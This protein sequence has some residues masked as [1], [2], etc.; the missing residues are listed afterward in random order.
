MI[1]FIIGLIGLPQLPGNSQPTVAQT[2]IG[3]TVRG[4]LGPNAL[5]VGVGPDGLLERVASPL[6]HDPPKLVVTG[7]TK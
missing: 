7:V 2:A 5:P 4:A 1:G 3:V 6:L